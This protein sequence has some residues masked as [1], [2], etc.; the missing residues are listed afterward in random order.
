MIYTDKSLIAVTGHYGV[1]KTNIAVNIA[2]A[3]SRDKAFDGLHI[4]L[5]DFDI[6]NPYYRSSDNINEAERYGFELI[7]PLYANSNV[8]VPGVVPDVLKAFLPGNAAIF[9]V[10]GD[11]SGAFALGGLSEKFKQ[12]GYEMFCVINMYRP[13]IVEPEDALQMMRDIELS[14]SMKITAVIN[15]S[16]LGVETT[17]ETVR[18]SFDYA[19]K[20]CKLSQLP[21][22]ATTA[23][24]SLI[25]LFD[26]QE[27]QEYKIT[28]I[29]N[30]TKR[31][32]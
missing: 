20:V 27:I 1:G 11:D 24:N 30:A 25:P 31:P 9:D 14:S 28:G 8:D 19:K 17:T 12:H 18:N 4:S 22:A 21:L 32:F 15:N 23:D 3:M 2:C 26:R 10:G 7:S 6:V 13:S 5:I 16:N 29:T